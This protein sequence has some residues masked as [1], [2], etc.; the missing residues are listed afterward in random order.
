[1]LKKP[2]HYHNAPITTYR[3]TSHDPMTNTQ[4]AK[5]VQQRKKHAKILML[6]LIQLCAL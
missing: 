3:Q 2:K 5:R 4:K 6:T 1:M